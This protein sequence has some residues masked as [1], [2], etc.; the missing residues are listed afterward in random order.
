VTLAC[1]PSGVWCDLGDARIARGAGALAPRLRDASMDRSGVIGLAATASLLPA[2]TTWRS[3]RLSLVWCSRGEEVE[4]A[5]VRTLIEPYGLRLD[6]VAGDWVSEDDPVGGDVELADLGV[7][8][9]GA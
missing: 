4:E 5:T 2:D 3:E 9:A 6:L 7:V 8:G 1:R